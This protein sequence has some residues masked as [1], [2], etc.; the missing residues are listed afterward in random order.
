MAGSRMAKDALFESLASVAKAIGSGRR[1]EIL[2]LLAQGER[3]VEEVAEAIDQSVA[4]TSHHLRVLHRAGLLHSRKE[5]TRVIY[6]LASDRVADLWAAVRDVAAAQLAEV[7]RLAATYLGE[8]GDLKPMGR[9]ELLTRMRRGE[10]VLW[11]V[12]PS[13]EYEAGHISGARSVPLSQL[14]EALASL[15]EGAEVVAYCR[16]PFCAYADEAVRRLGALGVT[17]NRLEAGFPEWRR[18]GLPVASEW[19][20]E[21]GHHDGEPGAS[22]RPPSG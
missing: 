18:A 21:N 7:E 17:A 11:D 12:R 1:A 22:E 16:G 5:G 15:P 19:D 2:E 3:S 9:E 13:L 20:E 14:E 10:V 4:N 6:G 8:R